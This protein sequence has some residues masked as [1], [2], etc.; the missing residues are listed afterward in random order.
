MMTVPAAEIQ[1][2]KM[3]DAADKKDRGGGSS[4]FGVLRRLG[5]SPVERLKGRAAKKGGEP[6]A[7]PAVS[8]P[9]DAAS[10]DAL[11]DQLPDDL[12][13]ALVLHD[14]AGLSSGAVANHLHIR[15]AD[16]RQLIRRARLELRR[17]PLARREEGRHP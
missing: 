10:F 5:A 6:P 11:V 14:K 15:E 3:A 12:R 9:P 7:T 8:L 16:A 17:L 1:V 2:T 4:L 13:V